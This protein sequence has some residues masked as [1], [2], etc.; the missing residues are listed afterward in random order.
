MP[1]KLQ[2][3]EIEKSKMPKELLLFSFLL[4]S[5]GLTAQSGWCG[6]H[7]PPGQVERT[8]QLPGLREP[9][10]IPVVVHIV[11]QEEA[12]S[13][14]EDQILSQ[15]DVLNADFRAENNDLSE[16]NANF[17]SLAAD[18][19]I[20]FALATVDP[21][22]DP[23]PGINYVHTDWDQVGSTFVF[24]SG[25]DQ[26]KRR[27]CYDELGGKTA[28]CPD[29]YLNI[30]V[31]ELAEGIAGQ[32]IFPTEVGEEVPSAED[33]VYISPD[34]F[35]RTG[36]VSPPYG[37][38]RTLTHEIGHYLNL[39]HLW[40]DEVCSPSICC[41]EELFTDFVEDTPNQNATYLGECTDNGFTCGT[42]DNVQNFMNFG[43]DAC[44]LMFTEG[45]KERVWAA[46]QEYR[47][48]LMDGECMNSCLT[49]SQQI[50]TADQLLRAWRV[51]SNELVL[52]ILESDVEWQLFSGN[53]QFI[54]AFRTAT[55][56]QHRIN[57]PLLP[58]GLYVL[59]AEWDTWVTAKKIII[60]Q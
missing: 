37:L 43:D 17:S 11:W 10:T 56:G 27:I 41:D 38:G 4:L 25:P 20:N 49:R 55:P 57:L 14:S 22:G 50:Q 35:G 44:Q 33:G 47:P 2:T 21:L 60:V 13:L 15:I 6:A 58:A 36:T 16:V 53:G 9:I 30:W 1:P 59:Q 34:R 51:E 18:M 52:E 54:Q 7:H 42:F 12:D 32:G 39:Y 23:H 24:E 46:L 5:A 40:G 19:E 26:G 29:C 3:S 48:G 31:G 28:W 45:Q 8:D